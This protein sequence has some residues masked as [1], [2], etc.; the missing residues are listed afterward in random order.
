MT[1][2]EFGLAALILVSTMFWLCAALEMMQNGTRTS[3]FG[4]RSEQLCFWC[5]LL[6]FCG[7][8][9]QRC[10]FWQKSFANED[11]VTANDFAMVF[12]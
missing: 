11:V 12:A 7:V 4:M 3:K 2:Y 5:M 9:E 6:I 10:C 8:C 1:H